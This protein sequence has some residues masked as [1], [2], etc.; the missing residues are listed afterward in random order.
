MYRDGDVRSEHYSPTDD[1]DTDDG[2]PP[3]HSPAR[4]CAPG[5]GVGGYDSDNGVPPQCSPARQ[6]VSGGVVSGPDALHTVDPAD[7]MTHSNNNVVGISLRRSVWPMRRILNYPLR[8]GPGIVMPTEGE[9]VNTQPV[10]STNVS[11]LPSRMDCRCG[12]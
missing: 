2:V 7:S 5:R 4:Q 6:G 1:H 11:M 3:R 12:S 9:T 8:L 10:L